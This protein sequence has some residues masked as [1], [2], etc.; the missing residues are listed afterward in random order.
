MPRTRSSFSRSREVTESDGRAEA[1]T[2]ARIL[3]FIENT[4]ASFLP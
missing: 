4:E 2:D 3:E 1:Q